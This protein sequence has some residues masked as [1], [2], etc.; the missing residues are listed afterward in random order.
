M[1]NKTK[2]SG[3]TEKTRDGVPLETGWTEL[4][5]SKGSIWLQIRGEGLSHGL[6]GD[7]TPEQREQRVLSFQGGNERVWCINTQQRGQPRDGSSVSE[8]GWETQCWQGGDGGAE[9]ED[10]RMCGAL[11]SQVK[12]RWWSL[13]QKCQQDFKKLKT[14]PKLKLLSHVIRKIVWRWALNEQGVKRLQI[15]FNAT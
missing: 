13:K 9:A 4:A 10:G 1:K 14:K 6:T 15:Q 2:Q 11:E 12:T 5:S 7:E 8:A 3:K